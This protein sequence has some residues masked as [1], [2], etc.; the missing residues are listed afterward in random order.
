MV[1]L[2]NLYVTSEWDLQQGVQDD[3][4]V[5]A[6]KKLHSSL[7]GT[8]D[9][10]FDNEILNLSKINHPNVV[11]VIGYCHEAWRQFFEQG[12]KQLLPTV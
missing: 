7:Q 5:I 3:G 12:G 9:A 8:T 2:L 10:A 4:E 6:V 1:R 11:R